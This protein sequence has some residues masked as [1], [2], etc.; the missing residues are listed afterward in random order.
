MKADAEEDAAFWA[1]LPY[2]DPF[3]SVLDELQEMHDRKGADYGRDE[4]PY[5]N[6][7][8]SADFGVP[9]WVGALVRANDK[10]RRLQ[11][12]ASGGTLKNEGIEDSLVDLAV[13]AIIALILWREEVLG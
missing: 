6:V 3:T 7:R 10:M 5:A 2:V 13:Y 12:V 8:G 11:K 4:D 1:A 9:P